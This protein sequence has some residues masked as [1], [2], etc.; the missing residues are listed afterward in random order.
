MLRRRVSSLIFALAGALIAVAAAAEEPAPGDVAAPVAGDEQADATPDDVSAENAGAYLAARN[1]ESRGDFRAAAHWFDLAYAADPADRNLLDAT[2]FS[3]MNLGE[4]EGAATLARAADIQGGASQ[5]VDFALLADA[6]RRDAHEELLALFAD[7][8]EAGPLFD[9]IAGAWAEYGLGHTG[10]AFARFDAMSEDARFHTI[11]LYHKALA[12]ALAGDFGGADA[13][14]SAPDASSLALGRRGII[15]HAQIISQL[16]QPERAL[17]LLERAFGADFDPELDAL[18]SA[19]HDRTPI[20]FDAVRSARDGIAEIL[21]NLATVINRDA[22]P[23][24]TLLHGRTALALRPDHADAMMLSAA[25]L[26]KM[27]QPDL[28]VAVYAGFP[29]DHP[30]HYAAELGRADALYAGGHKDAAIEVLRGL[31]RRNPDRLRIQAALGDMLRREE[32]WQEALAAYDAAA[33]LIPDPPERGRWPLH[34]ARGVCLERLGRH[35]ESEAALRAALV[36]EPEQPQV[37]NYLGYSLLERGTNLDEALDLIRRA[38]AAEPESG[39]IIDSLAWAYFQ[40][41]RYDDA[42]APMEE[43]SLLEPIE[44]VVTDHLGDVYWMNGRKRE[45]V[46]QWRR[47]LSFQ[48]EEKDAQRI[49]RK[50]DEG[51]DA[52]L[53]EERATTP[54]AVRAAGNGN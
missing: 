17:A 39:Y 24:L 22:D 16:E 35:D 10:E 19:L 9:G 23:A 25:M 20:P 15:A 33:A 50:L 53:E 14:L 42:L 2:L 40:L 27:D 34:F 31:A 4:I 54:P 5:L 7:G 41:G 36:L 47:A 29:T 43:A 8:R 37:L 32:R 6:A 13:I 44:P 48:P 18:R 1:A 30:A 46:F 11:G 51:L 49:R 38:V 12:L 3:L 26:E 45:A 21:F 28:A 52:V